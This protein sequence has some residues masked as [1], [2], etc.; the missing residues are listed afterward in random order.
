MKGTLTHDG[1]E[2]ELA[3]VKEYLKREAKPHF[4]AF[5]EEMS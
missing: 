5:L 2:L 4:L 1:F 3:M